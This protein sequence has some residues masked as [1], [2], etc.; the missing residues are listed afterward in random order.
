MIFRVS[1]AEELAERC[2]N[3][4][5]MMLCEGFIGGIGGQEDFTQ[6]KGVK[7]KVKSLQGIITT[8]SSLVSLR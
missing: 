8:S 4:S 6:I 1:H 3:V 2:G 5:L 7:P